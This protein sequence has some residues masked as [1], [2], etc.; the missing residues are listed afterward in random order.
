MTSAME[1]I[2][3]RI[4]I[5]A[6]QRNRHI[7]WGQ[8]HTK[9]VA[10]T[11][12]VDP[13]RPHLVSITTG[14]FVIQLNRQGMKEGLAGCWHQPEGEVTIRRYDAVEVSWLVV[15]ISRESFPA[16]Q[17]AATAERVAAFLA[18]VDDLLA[19]SFDDVFEALV[20]RP[21]QVG[22][23]E[24]DWSFGPLRRDGGVT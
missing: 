6:A 8:N 2:V 14:D 19:I 4:P 24:H 12:I 16:A 1:P 5:F 22:D 23:A 3:G 11:F 17:I 20:P 10:A 21:R 7:L 9:G 15:D 13:Q 18:F